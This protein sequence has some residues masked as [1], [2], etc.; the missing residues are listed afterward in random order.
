VTITQQARGSC[1]AIR[2]VM[3]VGTLPPFLRRE[4]PFAEAPVDIPRLRMI[5]AAMGP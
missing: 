5:I 2:K 1:A 3:Q 4:H